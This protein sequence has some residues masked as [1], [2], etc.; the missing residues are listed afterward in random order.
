MACSNITYILATIVVAI[1][2]TKVTIEAAKA[3]AHASNETFNHLG[4]RA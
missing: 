4:F 1:S 2:I 3:I